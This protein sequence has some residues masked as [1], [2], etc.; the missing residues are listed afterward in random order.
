[1]VDPTFKLPGYALTT[2]IVPGFVISIFN[3]V[4]ILSISL[5]PLSRVVI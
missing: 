4:I 3:P 2:T 1:M 5:E